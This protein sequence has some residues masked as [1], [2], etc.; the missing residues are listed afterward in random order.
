[1]PVLGDVMQC[2][3]GQKQ[4]GGGKDENQ[5]EAIQRRESGGQVVERV[6]DASRREDP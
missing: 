3:H 2:R 4:S 6:G 1:M 5:R